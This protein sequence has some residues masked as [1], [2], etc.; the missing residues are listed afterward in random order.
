MITLSQHKDLS[1][2]SRELTVAQR[3]MS[4]ICGSHQLDSLHKDQ[5]DFQYSGMRFPGKRMAIGCISY[6]TDV[7]IQIK[8]L[9]SYSI[10]LPVQ[11]RQKLCCHGEQYYSNTR[12]GLIVS[13][14]GEQ[15]LIIDK[16]CRK[17]QVVIPENSVKTVLSQML[18]QP[19][20][21]SVIFDAE[22]PF[23]QSSF[24][25]IWWSN[26][27][28]CLTLKQ[29]YSQFEGL[30][31]ISEDYESFLIKTL[32]LTQKN[33]YSE[34]LSALNQ[35][36][37]PKCVIVVRDF[38]HRFADQDLQVADMVMISGTSKSTLY[39]EFQHALHMSPMDYLR[40]YRL[41]Q[42]HQA[43]LQHKHQ[44]SISRLAYDWG[45]RHLGRFSQEYRAKYG[46][47]PSETLK[48]LS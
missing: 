24:L 38:I 7:S 27:Q 11:G 48:L 41:E 39:R 44:V 18:S 6:G 35:S 23:E 47:L 42:I 45:F 30:R 34:Q 9:G 5:L 20:R 2:A 46:M 37:L 28:Q 21:D 1:H 36:H 8:Q 29:D 25:Q 43:L 26:I 3:L 12:S 4:L 19:I 16:D 32:L 15:E 31:L 22:M 14:I 17:L 40:N 33:N 13:N 10:S